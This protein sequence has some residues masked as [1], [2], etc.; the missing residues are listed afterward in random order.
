MLSGD[1]R[2]RVLDRVERGRPRGCCARR[3]REGGEEARFGSSLFRGR[4]ARTGVYAMRLSDG[5]RDAIDAAA[6][7]PGK[8]VTEWARETL[9]AAA[10]DNCMIHKRSL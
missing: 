5:E 7:R 4:E 8:P 10:S 3:V 2:W 6:R 1:G 9:L